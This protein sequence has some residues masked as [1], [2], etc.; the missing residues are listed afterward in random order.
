MGP[1]G[2]EYITASAQ[3]HHLTSQEWKILY[4]EPVLAQLGNFFLIFL[5]SDHYQL[6]PNVIQVMDFT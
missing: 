5:I 6:P 1:W 2:D 4:T 3:K